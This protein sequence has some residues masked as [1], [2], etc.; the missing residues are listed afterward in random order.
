MSHR[1]NERARPLRLERRVEF[2]T[3]D[4]TRGFLERVGETCQRAGVFPDI[5]FGRTYVNLTL[6]GEGETLT[7]PLHRLAG[8]LDTLVG[9]STAPGIE[10]VPARAA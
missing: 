6:H 3:Y 9:A 4:A 10:A 5:S 7:E 8:E 2:P 1:W